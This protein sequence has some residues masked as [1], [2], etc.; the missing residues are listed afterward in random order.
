MQRVHRARQRNVWVFGPEYSLMASNQ[1]LQS[2]DLRATF[3]GAPLA[4]YVLPPFPIGPVHAPGRHNGV[5]L[6]AH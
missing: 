2:I 6:R 3:T 4:R 1:Q 5:G